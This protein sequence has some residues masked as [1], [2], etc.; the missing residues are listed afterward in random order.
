MANASVVESHQPEEVQAV[1]D[2]TQVAGQRLLRVALRQLRFELVG[3]LQPDIST[4][5]QF[6][7][8]PIHTYKSLMESKRDGDLPTFPTWMYSLNPTVCPRIVALKP[9]KTSSDRLMPFDALDIP[10]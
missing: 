8:T 1:A 2:P 3:L 7:H 5:A 4:L 6:I 9:E 10:P